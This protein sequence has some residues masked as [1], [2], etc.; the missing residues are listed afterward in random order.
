M[1]LCALQQNMQPQGGLLGIDLGIEPVSR[2]N[3]P[4]SICL[5]KITNSDVYTGS[6][7][8]WSI[9]PVLKF[10]VGRIKEAWQSGR[11]HWS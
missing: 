9:A 2:Y 5:E 8:E 3:V 4:L 6:L 1:Q 11:L 10:V 7:A